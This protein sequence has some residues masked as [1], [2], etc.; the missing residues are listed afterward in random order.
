MGLFFLLQYSVFRSKKTHIQKRGMFWSQMG[1]FFCVP[2]GDFGVWRGS[3]L[4][5]LHFGSHMPLG[6]GG[7]QMGHVF[8]APNGDFGVRS[9]SMQVHAFES[10]R[11]PNRT[12]VL[13]SRWGFWCVE[14]FN[15]SELEEMRLLSVRILRPKHREQERHKESYDATSKWGKIPSVITRLVKITAKR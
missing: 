7:P 5:P 6:L 4:G 12:P 15:S 10:W 8:C 11:S 13:R 2:N 14:R 1:H 9:G 3:V